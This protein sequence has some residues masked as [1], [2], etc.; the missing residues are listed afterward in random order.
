VVP[1]H[2]RD[3]VS[4]PGTRGVVLA[5]SMYDWANSAFPT[6]VITFVYATYFTQAVA[7]DEL[8]GT[9]QWAWTM[10]LSGVLIAV[11][12]PLLGAAADRNRRRRVSLM[13]ATGVC[14]IATSL[15]AFVH[16]DMLYASLLALLLVVIANTAFEI[17]M[18]FYN[19]FLPAIADNDRMGRV[20]GYG[21]ALGYAG[22]LCC[23]AVALVTLVRADP[24]LG[25]STEG[26]FN[27]RATNLLVAAWFL[28]FSIP[29]FLWVAEPQ[30]S[31]AVDTAPNS[32]AFG[33][34]LD[35]LR[36]VRRFRQIVRFLVARLVYNDGLVTVFAF[37]GI[38]AAGTFGM[39]LA[40][41][42]QFGIAINVAAGIGAWLFGYVDDRVG[43][44]FTVMVTLV[45][46][47]VFTLV[48]VL[49]P[50]KT[51]LWVAALGI[52]VFVG[53]NQ[54]ASRSLMGRLVPE[55]RQS[56]FF[57]F[58]AFSGKVTAFAGPFLLGA[59]T[60][61]AGSQRAGVATTLVF[62]VVGGVLLMGVDEAQGMEEARA[63]DRASSP[64]PS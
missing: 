43:A 62:F 35:T 53:P 20:S 10:A 41:V 50:S 52:G 21:W 17:G 4:A 57:G 8:T 58:F 60:E 22:G 7:V 64:A 33:R 31:T 56:E 45:A 28:V 36:K 9:T 63:A 11:L 51:W 6:L 55:D 38:Y 19:A 48:A 23:L 49:A 12:S 29:M 18:V 59:I 34:L 14:V 61:L 3:T 40:E 24:V 15:L 46:L 27:F 26:G 30:A 5:W 37:G 47:S 1:E 42:I 54:S 2:G 16:P 44:K 32:S 25:I 13:T 39:E